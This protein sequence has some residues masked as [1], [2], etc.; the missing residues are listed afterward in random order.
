MTHASSPCG[1]VRDGKWHSLLCRKPANLSLNDPV[2]HYTFLLDAPVSRRLTTH[3]ETCLDE[4][5]SWAVKDS[6]YAMI[7][8]RKNQELFDDL[9]SKITNQALVSLLLQAKRR[10]ESPYQGTGCVGNRES[11]C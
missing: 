5:A 6:T 7:I 1:I 10:S 4:R 3:L 8:A 9:N 2:T 11:K